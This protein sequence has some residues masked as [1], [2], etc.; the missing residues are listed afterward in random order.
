MLDF[1]ACRSQFMEVSLLILA[2]LILY[3][4]PESILLLMYIYHT[5][6]LYKKLNCSSL[7]SPINFPCH[8]FFIQRYS[9]FGLFVFSTQT[10]HFSTL[11]TI[12]E[13]TSNIHVQLH[14]KLWYFSRNLIWFDKH[15]CILSSWIVVDDI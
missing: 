7:L 1:N 3:D 13:R 8:N 5:C 12:T 4:G 14:N 6:Y 9:Y 11:R 2:F 15:S 10:W